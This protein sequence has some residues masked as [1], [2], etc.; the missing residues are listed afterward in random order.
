MEQE[1]IS[2]YNGSSWTN[3]SVTVQSGSSSKFFHL[4]GSFTNLVLAQ[5]N[6]EAYK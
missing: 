6:Y 2:F 3:A 5:F 4:T 1:K